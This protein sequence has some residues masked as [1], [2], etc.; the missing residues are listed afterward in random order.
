MRLPSRSVLLASVL[1]AS[2]P[3]VAQTA[4]TSHRKPT[5][6]LQFGPVVKD[7]PVSA[8]RVLD[9]EPADGVDAP[10][11]HGEE[12]LFRDSAGNTPSEISYDGGPAT[13]Y[14]LDH[15]ANLE[16]T[17]QEGE[18]VAHQYPLKE[19]RVAEKKTASYDADAPKIDG[20]PTHYSRGLDRNSEMV[21]SWYSAELQFALATV[22]N[23]PGWGKT[24]F[25]FTH[26][27]QTEPD[28]KLFRA[29]EG[30]TVE[31]AGTPPP[32]PTLLADKKAEDVSPASVAAAAQPAYRS[33]PKFQKA[34]TEARKPG[35]AE[36]LV[37]RWKKTV[38]LSNGECIEC[39]D[40]VIDMQRVTGAYKD[41]QNTAEQLDKV[42]TSPSDKFHAKLTIGQAL[43]QSNYGEPKRREAEQ[44]E[45]QIRAALE[46]VPNNK[47]GIFEHGR[48]LAM[49]GRDDE[50]KSAFQKYVDLT[51][52]SDRFHLRA[53]RFAET[54]H[55]ATLPS[56][57][58]FKLVTAQ[59]EEI[60]LDDM[61]GKVVLLD[62]WA[63]W[64][65]PCKATLP[66]LQRI[67]KDFKDEPLVVLSISSDRDAAVWK[68]FVQ[69]HNMDWP[70]YRDADG[71]LGNAYN[72]KAIPH[73]FTI[74]SNGVLQTEMIGSDADVRGKLKKL[75]KQAHESQEHTQSG[76]A[77]AEY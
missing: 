60:E 33:D 74:D 71:T 19:A 61:H 72:V 52:D 18:K 27:N 35:T 44:A 68:K 20:V 38:K 12:K 64:C 37:G 56:A 24:S 48:V 69:E 46:I 26:I 29:P 41:M 39:L 14:I 50:A 47:V 6:P 70:Q 55:L 59:G 42:A 63:T 57:P 15:V 66:T 4:A 51:K 2:V 54:P 5:L 53:V 11:V 40:H 3:L 77:G 32:Q 73:Y 75:L 36:D 23:T 22:I 30:M 17:W 67:A 43:L 62:F 1:F 28:A 49:L 21:D 45:A 10:K 16:L 58:P 9:F 25:R 31:K 7:A 13:I 76:Q 34:Y 65:G 8:I